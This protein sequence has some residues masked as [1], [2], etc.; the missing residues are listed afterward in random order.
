MT[1]PPDLCPWWCADR[2]ACSK[3]R[4]SARKDDVGRHRGAHAPALRTVVINDGLKRAGCPFWSA[5]HRHLA[6]VEHEILLRYGSLNYGN[7]GCGG[8]LARTEAWNRG[9]QQECDGCDSDEGGK[10]GFHGD[11]FGGGR[12]PASTA[13]AELMC[14]TSVAVA[15]RAFADE[16]PRV[17]RRLT[18]R[19]K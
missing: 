9:A 11:Q 8:D 13:R 16:S 1:P 6:G 12:R 4:T 19:R 10:W 3:L 18:S 17:R 14:G 5:V 7:R 2:R 15:A